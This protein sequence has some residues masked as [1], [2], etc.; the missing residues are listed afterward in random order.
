MET[1]SKPSLAIG[2][3][4]QSYLFCIDN[5]SPG[6]ASLQEYGKYNGFE[7]SVLRRKPDDV[8]MLLSEILSRAAITDVT[9]AILHYGS[10]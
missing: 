8:T 6:L 5:Q 2:R 9:I 1:G 10:D 4:S 7:Q 3:E